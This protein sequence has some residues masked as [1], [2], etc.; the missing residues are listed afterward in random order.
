MSLHARVVVHRRDITVDV[1]LDVR[2]GEVVA[3]LGPNGAGKST[4]VRAVA[5]LTRLD[6]GRVELDGTVLEDA[7]PHPVRLRPEHRDVGVVFQDHLLFPTMSAAEN[8]AFGLRA[9]GVPRTT[10][11][12]RAQAWL[13]RFEV[14]DLAAVRPARLSGGQ[15]QRVAL[16]RALAGSPRMLLLDEPFAALDAGSRVRSRAVLR[17]RLADYAGPT[18]LVTH[19]PAD[20]IALADRVVVLEAGRVAQTGTLTDLAHRPRTSYVAELLGL[21]LWTASCRTGVVEPAPGVALRCP[22]LPDGEVLVAVPPAAVRLHTTDRDVPAGTVHWQASVG[23]VET[24]TDHVRVSVDG[25]LPTTTTLP[26]AQAARLGL[27]REEAVWV[28][29]DTSLVEVY[30]R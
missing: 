11:R 27:G 21:T 28:S 15:A 13:D 12:Q 8:V 10:A 3:L 25:A 29:L 23:L 4:T 18:V 14:G 26:T 9:H 19:E 16:A 30:P 2:A 22:D 7:G 5:G 24:Y 6:A 20:A 1:D 17:R